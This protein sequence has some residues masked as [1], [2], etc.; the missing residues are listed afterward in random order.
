M[1]DKTYVFYSTTTGTA[2]ARPVVMLLNDDDT[3]NPAVAG[4]GFS[5]TDT[6]VQAIEPMSMSMLGGALDTT[7]WTFNPST[8]VVTTGTESVADVATDQAEV[9]SQ[10]AALI[11][12]WEWTQRLEAKITKANQQAFSDWLN[13]LRAIPSN[14]LWSTNPKG[15]AIPQVPAVETSTLSVGVQIEQ[16]QYTGDSTIPA[17]KLALS[18][19][20][21]LQPVW[22]FDWSDLTQFAGYPG[23]SNPG[24]LSFV[25]GRTGH[26]SLR[27]TA[28]VSN[29]NFGVNPH[30]IHSFAA[31]PGDTIYIEAWVRGTIRALDFQI[32][33]W[34]NKSDTGTP[35]IAGNAVLF[36]TGNNI[37]GST[38]WKKITAVVTLSG[39]G[40]RWA[41]IRL[42]AY[43]YNNGTIQWF[44]VD[45]LTVTRVP[46]INNSYA[47]GGAEV[48]L[49][50]TA[51]N[52]ND[53]TQITEVI[54][55]SLL[56]MGS[57]FTTNIRVS[58]RIVYRSSSATDTF[59]GLFW[60]TVQDDTMSKPT[61]MI[62]WQENKLAGA[63]QH[64]S[65]GYTFTDPTARTGKV[66][67]S[68]WASK[69]SSIG[70]FSAVNPHISA[71]SLPKVS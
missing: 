55:T 10:I 37:G 70:T 48:D 67:Y 12:E 57:S 33:A 1:A 35:M 28:A 51:S 9:S 17:Q 47:Q 43:P 59:R 42:I 58:C 54:S 65:F 49:T 46:I 66:S 32:A 50:G 7:S 34:D 44:D 64:F 41:G 60:L 19:W 71:I 13:A 3:L 61:A 40:Y 24:I 2:T 21:T 18:N 15:I 29:M 68:L 69:T 52:L 26:R 22:G 8:G 56:S 31:G 38:N 39:S 25:S 63:N 11:A 4:F 20:S 53:L 5:D 62:A 23:D 6:A 30:R 36:S 27:V 16:S 14:P 45:A